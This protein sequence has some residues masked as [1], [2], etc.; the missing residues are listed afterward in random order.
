VSTEDIAQLCTFY[1]LDPYAVA[2][3]LNEFRPIYAQLHNVGETDDIIR[4]SHLTTRIAPNNES[5]DE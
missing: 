4:A 3:E 2:C 5:V 1:N